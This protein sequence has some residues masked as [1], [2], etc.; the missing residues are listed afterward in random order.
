MSKTK[1]AQY[2]V[3]R[4]PGGPYFREVWN[5]HAHT[6]AQRGDACR[7]TSKRKSEQR[8]VSGTLLRDYESEAVR[9]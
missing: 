1:R 5:G 3:L 6:T 7:F 8:R 9:W 4:K 2:W